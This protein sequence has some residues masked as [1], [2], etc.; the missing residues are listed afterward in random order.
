MK[1]KTYLPEKLLGQINESYQTQLQNLDSKR[2][3]AEKAVDE[4]MSGKK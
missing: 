3:K 4:I 2:I 1:Q